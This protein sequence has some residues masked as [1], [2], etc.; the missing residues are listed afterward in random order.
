MITFPRR[1]FKRTGRANFKQVE[2]VQLLVTELLSNGSG[3]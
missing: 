2:G 3:P 1:E